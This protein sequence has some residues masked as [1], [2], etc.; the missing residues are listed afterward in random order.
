MVGIDRDRLNTNEEIL[1]E[2]RPHWRYLFIPAALVV[3]TVT[4]GFAAMLLNA[5]LWLKW[6]C[7]VPMAAAI[8]FGAIEYWVWRAELFA[9]TTDR[10]ISQKGIFSKQSIEIPIDRVNSV[11]SRRTLL[12]RVIGCGD[13]MVE[14]A[15][16]NGL[17]EFSN[18]RK[19]Q[20]VQQAIY[21][22][23][24]INKE[25]DFAAMAKAQHGYSDES[26]PQPQNTEMAAHTATPA[27]SGNEENDYETAGELSGYETGENPNHQ[28]GFYSESANNSTQMGQS[29]DNQEHIPQGNQMSG[30]GSSSGQSGLS[31]PDQIVQLDGLRKQGIISEAEFQTKKSQ[32]LERM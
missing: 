21:R 20:S 9:I 8:V 25:Q 1:L 23:I 29:L 26:R 5:P 32:L 16:E 14:S 10:L 18:I 11:S 12:E 2:L 6:L 17:Q 19:P 28:L 22:A 13:L 7:A 15:S 3:M 24:E 27:S 31:I 30:A 4:L